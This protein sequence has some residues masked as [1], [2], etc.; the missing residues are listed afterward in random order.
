MGSYKRFQGKMACVNNQQELD[1]V[2]EFLNKIGES[3]AYLPK[4]IG[5]MNVNYIYC[6]C[7]EEWCLSSKCF[8]DEI[9]TLDE[10]KM[11]LNNF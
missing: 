6:H 4:E 11:L 7:D 9:I 8:D 10:W 2:R 3:T 1:I 5:S